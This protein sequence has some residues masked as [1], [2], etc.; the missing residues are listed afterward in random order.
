MRRL[1]RRAVHY[2][3]DPRN[4]GRQTRRDPLH[5]PYRRIA[6]RDLGATGSPGLLRG[7]Q[8]V[9]GHVRSE[10]GRG[11]GVFDLAGTGDPALTQKRLMRIFSDEILAPEQRGAVACDGGCR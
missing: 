2:H 8:A 4:A 6:L 1:L 9:S 5:A 10:P 7:A 11:D 3:A